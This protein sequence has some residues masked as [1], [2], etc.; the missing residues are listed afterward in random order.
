M[1]AGRPRQV[2]PRTLYF[3]AQELYWGFKGLAEGTIRLRFDQREYARLKAEPINAPIQFSRQEE[4]KLRVIVEQEVRTGRT[5]SWQKT[6]RLQALKRSESVGIRNYLA[7]DEAMRRVKVPGEPDVLRVLMAPNTTPDQIRELCK[8]AF[9]SSTVTSESETQE[10]AIPAWPIALGSVLPRYLSEYA[11]QFTAAKH[12]PRF[13]R[14][15]VSRRPTNRSK[16]FWF[17]A[18]ALAGAVRGIKTRTA[19]NLVGSTRP[20]QVFDFS[21]QAKLKRNPSTR[22]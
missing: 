3:L 9:M 7:Q 11:E 1:T 5:K 6:D 12:D 4:A 10:V 21:R 16:Q 8:E 13:P 14:C 22:R 19:I 15:D 17:L 20:E 2:E 18:R